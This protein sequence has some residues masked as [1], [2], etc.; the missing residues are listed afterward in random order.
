MKKTTCALLACTLAL[1]AGCVKTSD[2]PKHYGAFS[3]YLEPAQFHVVWDARTPET[4]Y[5]SDVRSAENQ[6]GSGLTV[7]ESL[8][9]TLSLTN[10]FGSGIV[11]KDNLDYVDS[12]EL[13]KF[14]ERQ[15]KRAD[16]ICRGAEL[17]LFGCGT[18]QLSNIK[19]GTLRLSDIAY[20][21]SIKENWVLLDDKGEWLFM[22][23]KYGYTGL[24][25]D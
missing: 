24:L 8:L 23:Q 2:L 10:A 18:S 6:N 20:V 3:G 9:D 4:F 21:I 13:H 14:L 15:Q 5:M 19:D 11:L 1:F 12:E 17:I 25:K 16:D 7:F 22:G